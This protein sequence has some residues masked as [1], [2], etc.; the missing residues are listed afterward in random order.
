MHPCQKCQSPLS[1]QDFPAD[2]Y[3]TL[4]VACW[5]CWRSEIPETLARYGTPGTI[6]TACGQGFGGTSGFD[7]HRVGGH[8]RSPGELAKNPRLRVK[9]GIWVAVLRQSAFISRGVSANGD[10]TPQPQVSAPQ[11]TQNA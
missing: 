9:D 7:S 6:C 3:T 4:C 2:P 5:E 8:C 11:A 1:E 10:F